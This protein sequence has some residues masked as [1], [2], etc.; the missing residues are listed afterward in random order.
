MDAAHVARALGLPPGTRIGR[1]TLVR[2]I[3]TGGMAEGYLAQLRGAERFDK[4]VALKRILPQFANDPE[5]AR[6]FLDEARLA[7]RLHHPNVTQVLDFGEFEGEHFITMEFVHGHHLLAL[8]RAHRGRPLAHPVALTIVA[9]IARALHHMHELRDHDGSPLGLVHRDV[10]PSNVLLSYEGAIKLTDFGIAKAVELTSATRTGSF[11]GK[12]GYSSPEQCRGEII[13][14]RSDIFAL[15]IL[16]YETTT[17]ARAFSGPNEFAV[18]GRVA[19]GDYVHPREIEPEYPAGLA[20]LVECAMALDA[21]Q[22]FATAADLAEAVEAYAHEAG[23]RLTPARVVEAMGESFGEAPPLTSP[24][25]SMLLATFRDDADAPR[26][27]SIPPARPRGVAAL[28]VAG[29]VSVSA[30]AYGITRDRAAA[31]AVELAAP[32]PEPTTPSA[33]PQAPAPIGDARARE[34]GAATGTG[35]APAI[36]PAAPITAAT[37]AA[38]RDPVE[39]GVPA[40]T[41]AVAGARAPEPTPAASPK[42]SR[43]KRSSPRRSAPTGSNVPANLYPPG[44]RP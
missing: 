31:P 16:L 44:Y 24:D 17:G 15:G 26:T 6:M 33:A 38:G 22:R 9:S 42:P 40:S 3:A 39:V 21:S 36:A 1:Y 43:R 8:M 18:L 34:A 25:E 14:R 29:V 5:F 28:V 32:L 30:V 35:E 12:L 27:R 4:L 10:S 19:R 37:A 41:D 2:R 13:D 20:S 11:K 7:S 23:W